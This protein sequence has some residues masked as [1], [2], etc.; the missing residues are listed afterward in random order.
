MTSPDSGIGPQVIDTW[1]GWL[2]FEYLPPDLQ[3]AEDATQERDYCWAPEAQR[4]DK[5][6]DSW[7]AD[8]GATDTEKTLLA[9]LGYTVPAEG[10]PNYPLRTRVSWVTSTLRKRTWPALETQTPTTS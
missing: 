10:D 4:Y 5:T 3:R 6:T 9:H 2:V 1:R 7:Y 8:R